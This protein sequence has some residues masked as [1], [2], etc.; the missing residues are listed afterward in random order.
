MNALECC[1]RG[2]SLQA[3][4]LSPSFN[5][6]KYVV[7]DYN[8]LPIAITYAFED[9]PESKKTME[10]FPIG[11]NF[12]V[13]KSLSFK[14]KLGAMDLLIHYPNDAPGLMKGLPTQLA[15]YKIT[16][17]KLKHG[18]KKSQSEFVI[19]IGNN[20]NQISILESAELSEKWIEIEKIAIK[21][22]VAP[23]PVA[24]KGPKTGLFDTCAPEE[25][26][27]DGTAKTEEEKKAEE[28]PAPV[29]TE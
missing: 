29:E 15:S 4:Y 22:P 23:K 17:G 26:K 7:E 5:V 20:L 1:C 9:K 16:E 12:P 21:K 28:K 2:A 18:D 13:T 14:N 10:L 27:A 3:A 19:K 8:T 6:S 24:P 25:K 11:S